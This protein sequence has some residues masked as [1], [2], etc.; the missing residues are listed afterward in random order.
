MCFFFGEMAP[1][2]VLT[3]EEETLDS[4]QEKLWCAL[5]SVV[6]L[7]ADYLAA[8][9]AKTDADDEHGGD[10]GGGKDTA[11]SGGL[12]V[13]LREA[14]VPFSD[15]HQLA[16]CLFMACHTNPVD[17]DLENGV[18]ALLGRPDEKEGT[19][20]A[21]SD[22]VQLL[23][24]AESQWL[25]WHDSELKWRAVSEKH[26]MSVV[27]EL[28]EC[29]TQDVEPFA[30][31][32]RQE[33]LTAR[34]V[35]A[36]TKTLITPLE[37][38]VNFVEPR[39]CPEIYDTLWASLQTN[40]EGE[41]GNYDVLTIE[42]FTV[43]FK[44]FY[45]HVFA[46]A[47]EDSAAVAARR[48]WFEHL[49]AKGVFTKKNFVAAC[50]RMCQ[51]YGIGI[52]DVQFLEALVNSTQS[53]SQIFG[54]DVAAA[55]TFFQQRLSNQTD[56]MLTNPMN[57]YA[58]EELDEAKVEIEPFAVA[59]NVNC[60]V[61]YGK[62]GVGK[63]AL[64]KA[65]AGRL[66]CV[67]LDIEELAL[68]AVAKAE[69]GEEDLLGAQLAN[70]VDLDTSVP[71][72]LLAALVRRKLCADETL[73]RGYVFSDFP[74]A[75]GTEANNL[76]EFFKECGI[77]DVLVPSFLLHL[78]CDEDFYTERSAAALQERVAL[79][80]LEMQLRE[81]MEQEKAAEE[82]RRKA[83]VDN[84]EQLR[85]ALK[86]YKE[87]LEASATATEEEEDTEHAEKLEAARI[88]AENAE[89]ELPDAI[90]MQK[91]DAENPPKPSEE[92]VERA[93]KIK[94]LTLERIVAQ[95]LAG[96]ENCGNEV[97]SVVD[98]PLFQEIFE[99]ASFLNRCLTVGC[100]SSIED[101]V[102]YI[103]SALRLQPCILPRNLALLHKEEQQEEG[104][105]SYSIENDMEI[106]RQIEDVAVN[107]MGALIST[108][109]KRFCPV[110]FTESRVL[111][112]GTAR[113]GCIFRQ[114]LYY[115]ASE[116]KLLKFVANPLLYLRGFPVDREPIFIFSTIRKEDAAKCLVFDVVSELLQS[117]HRQL[118]L[119]PMTFKDFAA[120]WEECR[121]LKEQRDGSLAAREKFEVVERKLRADR[122]KK[123]RAKELKKKKKQLPRPPSKKKKQTQERRVQQCPSAGR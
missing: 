113:Y 87:M 67:H 110:T 109:W 78:R 13:T 21:F 10:G 39:E 77:L 95:S 18:V 90:E 94:K 42:Q 83:L 89:K 62:R 33:V 34:S 58:P 74:I 97:L 108:R 112:E 23:R 101:A 22:F 84:V 16:E 69:S 19:L 59:A 31:L 56:R 76:Q 82:S 17:S 72:S 3:V 5:P 47:T 41:A 48:V 37:C 14:S 85:D 15:I 52:D 73:Y 53:A 91:N 79:R 66:N 8:A 45:C 40:A 1:R 107:E 106:A 50:R 71:L 63:T 102:E 28:L 12:S 43:F 4:V 26:H 117:L 119:T 96:E 35:V 7:R 46:N 65:L 105:A 55:G 68:E 93:A 116:K 123:R 118:C 120:C 88:A 38:F 115:L 111:I 122:L 11:A 25:D 121:K 29:V 75:H 24:D 30:L 44:W 32:P 6:K 54:D 9:E 103:V 51:V 104:V 98:L 81:A 100:T 64:A 49:N 27:K 57:I 70:F 80:Q 20:Y 61:I 99:R 60:I 2:V 92:S 86:Q 114:R 36:H